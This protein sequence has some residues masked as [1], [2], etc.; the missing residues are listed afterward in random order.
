[1][2][3]ASITH[4][5]ILPITICF[6]CQ[7]D[8]NKT[9]HPLSETDSPIEPTKLFIDLQP[10]IWPNTISDGDEI[11]VALL[12]INN[13]D[14]ASISLEEI[15][16]WDES[17]EIM[18]PA[19]SEVGEEDI[20]GDGNLDRIIQFDHDNLSQSGILQDSGRIEIRTNTLSAWDQYNGDTR[21]T[22]IFP[23]PIG[24]YAVGTKRYEWEDETR[25][26]TNMEELEFRKL[27]IQIWYPT[28]KTSIPQNAQP[29]AHYLHR[30]EGMLFANYLGIFSRYYDYLYSY[31]YRDSQLSNDQ[32][33]WP[34]LVFS[35]GYGVQLANQAMFVQ[36]A[37]SA[38]FIVIG[39]QHTYYTP[40]TLFS[41]G[42][43]AGF[44]GGSET[45]ST[46]QEVWTAD[47][48]FVLDKI[49]DLNNSDDFFKSRI[50]IEKMG[51]FGYSFGGSTAAEVC[52]T[53][54]R[55]L[56][57]M[58]IDGTFYGDTEQG[59]DQDFLLVNAAN[60]FD[61]ETRPLLLDSVQ[62]QAYNLILSQ[63]KHS[64]FDDFAI[65]EDYI[66][67]LLGG[68]NPG[69]GLGTIDANLAYEIVNQYGNAFFQQ[70]VKGEPNSLLEQ[71]SPWAE[72][73]F[74]EWN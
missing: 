18:A 15:S 58:N 44:S 27:S 25:P 52:R 7:T 32:E 63:A 50:D 45:I 1:M 55:I 61:E 41:D 28:D 66:R 10:E 57:G 22:F 35:H 19:V 47:Q 65:Q 6:G 49:E 2:I 38:G 37:A 59:F 40:I 39:I 68:A 74:Q 42:T 17:G 64:N 69:L 8:P 24:E 13:Q 67:E 46:T 53:D 16:M 29:T 56:A 14:I 12:A 30:E 48:R 5:M 54:E 26:D 3:K 31:T 71:D 36:N 21:P 70:H 72:A 34:V 23:E 62:G 4:T 60:H 43:V 33:K 9:D 20:D 73:D 51:S 11:Y